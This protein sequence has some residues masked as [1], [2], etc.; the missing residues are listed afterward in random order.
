MIDLREEGD[1]I[2]VDLT[3]DDAALAELLDQ[4]YLNG[5]R[6]RSFADLEPTLEDVFLQVTKG[7]VS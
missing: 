4:F 7:T 3:A 5:I 2:L 6:V 1:R